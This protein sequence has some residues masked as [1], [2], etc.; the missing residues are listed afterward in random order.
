M[1]SKQ[2]GL[3]MEKLKENLQNKFHLSKVNK[4]QES[5]QLRTRINLQ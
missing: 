3:K 5:N 2:F 1:S 4:N